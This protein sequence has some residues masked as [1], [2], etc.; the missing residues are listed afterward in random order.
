MKLY[1]RVIDLRKGDYMLNMRNTAALIVCIFTLSGCAGEFSGDRYTSANAGEVQR[2]DHGTV[3]SLRKVELKPDGMGMG[4]A[5][6][7][8]GGG[9]VG[10]MFGKGGGKLLGAAAG[11]AAG[12]VGGHAIENRAQD[13][14]EYT[15][16]LDTGSVITLA[17]GPS[18]VMSVGQK[19]YVVN[20]NRG[21]SKVVP[22]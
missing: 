18:P 8:V 20:S 17:Q 19:V 2:S 4:T 16:R 14:V 10:S 7:A 9:L 3:I 5:L 1:N 6:G 11:A 21:K 15:V 22:D 13:G 12:G